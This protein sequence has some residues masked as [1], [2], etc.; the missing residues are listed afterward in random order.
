MSDKKGRRFQFPRDRKIAKKKEKAT[1]VDEANAANTDR[2][3]INREEPEPPLFDVK[4]RHGAVK[5]LVAGRD[6]MIVKDALELV[7]KVAGDALSALRRLGLGNHV[8]AEGIVSTTKRH[9]KYIEEGELVDGFLP[10]DVN[11]ADAAVFR[12][13]LWLWERQAESFDEK[14]TKKG[15]TTSMKRD[16]ATVEDWNAKIHDQLQL[17]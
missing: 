6:R 9:L 4:N 17:L 3:V 13:A 10:F 2:K 11:A 14:A 1:T 7:A 5:F 15:M 8:R 16:V 12:I